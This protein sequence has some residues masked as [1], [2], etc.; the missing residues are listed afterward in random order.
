MPHEEYER[1]GDRIGI[2]HATADGEARPVPRINSARSAATPMPGAGGRGPMRELARVYEA[3]VT[4]GGPLLDPVTI[5]AISARHRTEMFDETFGIVVD[6]GLGLTVDSAA[7][8][9]HCSRRAFGHGGHLSSVAFCD[10]EHAV[11]VAYVCNGMPAR[12]AHYARLDAVS[13]A[14]Y[15]DLGLAE[16][17][18]RG[19]VKQ[20]PTVGL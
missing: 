5:A 15:V 17:G 16:P 18:V 19:R 1:Y 10:P 6:W 20:Y 12:D 2:M 13:S 8:G 9:S 7:M 3:L 11:V 4:G 14:A